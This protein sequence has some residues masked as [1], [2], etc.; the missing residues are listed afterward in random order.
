MT[1][2]DYRDFWRNVDKS[3][4]SEPIKGITRP[5]YFMEQDDITEMMV[6]TML[7]YLPLD[8][9]ILEL[10]CNTGRNLAGLKRAGYT[11]IIGRGD[12]PAGD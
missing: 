12:K 11:D 4:I 7:R 8:S 2:F 5:E 6:S 3:K 9:S 10:G 1:N